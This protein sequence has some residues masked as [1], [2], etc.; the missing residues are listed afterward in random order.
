MTVPVRY[1]AGSGPS[2]MVATAAHTHVVVGYSL[3]I[4]VV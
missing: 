3:Q 1:S 2:V 4:A